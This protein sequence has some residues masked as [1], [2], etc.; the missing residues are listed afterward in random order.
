LVLFRE[1]VET[2]RGYIITVRMVS[3]PIPVRSNRVNRAI[4]AIH[5]DDG[6][7]RFFGDGIDYLLD[8]MPVRHHK[9]AS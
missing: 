4:A 7:R 8:D 6:V 1:T 5:S 2:Q 3:P 9:I